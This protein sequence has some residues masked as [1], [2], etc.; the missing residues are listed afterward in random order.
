MFFFECITRS[1]SLS[2]EEKILI[3]IGNR[4]LHVPDFL[5]LFLPFQVWSNFSKMFFN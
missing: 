2:L 4:I 5:R 3:L 1:S